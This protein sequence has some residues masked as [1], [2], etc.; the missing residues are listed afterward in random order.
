MYCL[1]KFAIIPS[2]KEIIVICLARKY[3]QNEQKFQSY[4]RRCWK[5]KGIRLPFFLV[6]KLK[7]LVQ[8]NDIILAEKWLKGITK[9]DKAVWLCD[10]PYKGFIKL[11]KLLLDV[12]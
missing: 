8:D 4:K 1:L 11:F 5:E 12:L 3:G 9:F 6:T 10:F 7:H 2:D